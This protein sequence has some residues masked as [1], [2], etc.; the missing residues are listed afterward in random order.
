MKRPLL[1]MLLFASLVACGMPATAVSTETSTQEPTQAP[2]TAPL[3]TTTPV[4]PSPQPV[5]RCRCPAVFP[6]QPASG[7]VG[8]CY[9]G[10]FI[11][12]RCGYIGFGDEM[13]PDGTLCRMV[14]D[15]QWYKLHVDSCPGCPMGIGT[16]TYS[17]PLQ[18]GMLVD[19]DGE[20]ITAEGGTVFM[21][22]RVTLCPIQ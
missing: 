15:G 1:A 10:P 8:F 13:A 3:P 16:T 20:F 11:E 5:Q 6:T 18:P 19:V 9:S 14:I 12:G 4:P 2:T 17:G 21:P 22:E 7:T